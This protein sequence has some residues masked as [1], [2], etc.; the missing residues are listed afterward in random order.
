MPGVLG[1]TR[2]VIEGAQG[3]AAQAAA[4][5]S[6]EAVKA[7][8]A[9]LSGVLDQPEYVGDVETALVHH[10]G[11]GA[12][13]DP[14][15]QAYTDLAARIEAEAAKDRRRGVP[16]LFVYRDAFYDGE[17]TAPHT[18]LVRVPRG[19]DVKFRSA[20]EV[21]EGVAMHAF[22]GSWVE[23]PETK[24]K[25]WQPT[26]ADVTHR[27]LS[28]VGEASVLDG[29]V[30]EPGASV[31]LH[32]GKGGSYA[33]GME[34]SKSETAS[35]GHGGGIPNG[36]GYT[37]LNV[38]R[39]NPDFGDADIKIAVGWGEIEEALLQRIRTTGAGLDNTAGM[40]S[41]AMA[42]ERFFRDAAEEPV[43]DR[44]PEIAKIL[45]AAHDF[46]QAAGGVATAAGAGESHA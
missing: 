27:S 26:T 30:L 11:E 4:D 5:A 46:Q 24:E 31:R 6:T 39:L 25:E 12:F 23:N 43:S 7:A 44:A 9:N 16:V 28:L 8:M 20:V 22:T 36:Y 14:D 35:G 38:D 18:V 32:K 13:T 1:E 34:L 37:N 40:V 3:S 33:Q 41:E 17:A 45:A 10:W 15:T 29:D 2:G 42:V 19:G 21:E